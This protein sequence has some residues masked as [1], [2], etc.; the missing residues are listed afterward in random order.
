MSPCLGLSPL[1]SRRYAS[2]VAPISRFNFEV[3]M[4]S[5]GIDCGP[6]TD[7]NHADSAGDYDQGFRSRSAG[8]DGIYWPPS[9]CDRNCQSLKTD[10]LERTDTG[11]VSRSE[12]KDA[13]SL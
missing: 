10:S 6:G 13:E 7:K 3:E 5:C 4:L 8:A 11:G 1:Y 12:V 2:I 9:M